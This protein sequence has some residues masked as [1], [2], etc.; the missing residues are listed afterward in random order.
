MEITVNQEF[1][2]PGD[3]HL[4]DTHGIVWLLRANTIG[5]DKIICDRL[6]LSKAELAPNSR[7]FYK[8]R[9]V[10]RLHHT[11]YNKMDGFLLGYFALDVHR[12][13]LPESEFLYAVPKYDFNQIQCAICQRFYRVGSE[14]CECVY[15][16]PV[17]IIPKI[18]LTGV[19]ILHGMNDDIHMQDARSKILLHFF[20]GVIAAIQT[21]EEES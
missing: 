14:P 5:C 10:G 7:A 11:S 12:T 1:H 19:S 18:T 6:A 16:S 8:D 15:G 13:S 9:P 3:I 17:L 2:K 21:N 20:G 4:E